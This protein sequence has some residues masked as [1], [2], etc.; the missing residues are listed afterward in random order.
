VDTGGF[1]LI[2]ITGLLVIVLSFALDRL[3]AAAMPVRTIYLVIRAPGVVLHE[4]SHILACLLTGA[5]IR[6]IVLFSKDGG[7]VTCARPALPLIGD[8]IISTA[9]L[10]LL[11]LALSFITWVFATYLGCI[12]PVFPVAPESPGAV[13]DLGISFIGT[14][15]VNLLTRFNGWFLLFLYLTLSIVLSVA[16]SMQ[17]MKNA[18][19]GFIL[20][21]LLGI[22]IVWS[23]IPGAVSVLEALVRI[24]GYGFTLGFVYGLVALA[25]SLPLLAWYLYAHRS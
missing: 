4:C 19:A 15:P 23:G 1:F 10:F 9:P 25:A 8:I 3:W 5:R 16:P 20:L 17:D 2:A 11:P 22:C 18:T 21:V 24:L 7:S 13:I 12:V 6:N 14:F